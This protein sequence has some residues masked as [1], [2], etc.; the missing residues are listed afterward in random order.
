MSLNSRS[1]AMINMSENNMSEEAI[2]KAVFKES[3]NIDYIDEELHSVATDRSKFNLKRDA[4][5]ISLGSQE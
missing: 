1:Q 5:A 4:S 3:K 2:L